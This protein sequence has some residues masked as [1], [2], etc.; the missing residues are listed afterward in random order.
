M[1]TDHENPS[2]RSP[3]YGLLAIPVTIAIMLAMM[4]AATWNS[5]DYDE[6]NWNTLL[7][8]TTVLLAGGLLGKAPRLIFEPVGTRPSLVSLG[9]AAIIVTYSLYF[10]NLGL[11]LFAIAFPAMARRGDHPGR[12]RRRLRL[13]D[14]SRRGGP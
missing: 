9:F 10:I 12:H 6:S 3:L 2:T 7:M 1:E 5:V 14:S 4:V 11:P 8:L 13:C